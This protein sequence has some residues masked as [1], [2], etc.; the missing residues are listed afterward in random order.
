V[1]R[2]LT[3]VL[4]AAIV[5]AVPRLAAACATCISLSDR[6]GT[7]P[8]IGLILMPFV[9]GVGIVGAL[10]WYAGIRPRQLAD[11]FGSWRGG[12]RRRPAR[13]ALSPSTNTETT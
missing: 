13:A 9:V 7:W 3:P 11:R 6:G 8:Y 5:L 10:A 1:S 12:L 2:R 4:C